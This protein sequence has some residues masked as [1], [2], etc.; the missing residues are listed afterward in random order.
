[1]LDFQPMSR[2]S[3]FDNLVTNE[4]SATELL[5][6]AMR[7]DPLRRALLALF[8]SDECSMKV[9]DDDT[10]TQVSLD[11]GRPDLVVAN[12]DVYAFIEVKVEEHCR[13]TGNQPGG[14]F[15][16]LLSDKR[17]QRWLVFLVPS[18]W[19]YHSQLKESLT[20]L[21]DAHVGSGI[22]TRVVHWEAVLD[23][24]EKTSIQNAALSPVLGEFTALFSSWFLPRSIMFTKD[25]VQTLFSK[26][27]A[28]AFSDLLELIR[29]IGNTGRRLC[30]CSE[31][32]F[33][34]LYFK[35]DD[36]EYLLWVG[37]W[38]DFWKREGLPVAFGVKD[39]WPE[40][41]QETF[42]RVYR[43]E[44][45]SFDGWTMGWVPQQELESSKPLERIWERI[46]P[47]LQALASTK[48]RE[49]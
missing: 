44:T 11:A 27:F 7:F 9:R 23:V 41:V 3:I 5:C 18:G 21:N 36:G 47:V 32:A 43:F 16:S 49:S 33:G 17:P 20:Q 40:W 12:D 25:N 37:F 19:F 26:E 10:D 22:Q 45:R 38:P 35:N 28:V 34:E 14:Y 24:L 6:N 15:N 46:S 1:L 13:L 4:N 30:K 42:R 8:F 29:Q 2:I 39:D 48:V 31:R